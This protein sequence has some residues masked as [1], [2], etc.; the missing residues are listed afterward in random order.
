[1]SNPRASSTA[2]PSATVPVPPTSPWSPEEIVEEA[3]AGDEREWVPA[4][5]AGVWIRPLLFDTVHGAWVNVVRMRTEGFIS[6][7]HHPAPVHA[8]V[9]KGSWRYLERDWVATEGSYVFEP[10][11]D[12]H[13]LWANPGE[14]LTVFHISA[15]LVEV[16]ETGNPLSHTDVFSR[17]EQASRHYAAVGLGA[18][19]VKKYIR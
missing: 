11:G 14:S 8:H 2:G 10:P 13:T 9:L 12:T 4:S 17:I 18:D 19:Y 1:M 3:V 15:C 6:R 5:Q 16:D 7:H